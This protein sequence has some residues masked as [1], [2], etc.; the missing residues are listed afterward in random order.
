[1]AGKIYT[2]FFLFFLCFNRFLSA[3]DYYACDC[4]L[5]EIYAPLVS[6]V[7]ECGL[8][9]Q[10]SRQSK[11]ITKLHFGRERA[12]NLDEKIEI[13]EDGYKRTYMRVRTEEGEEGWVNAN[14]VILCGQGRIT[15]CSVQGVS[16]EKEPV[17]NPA[18]FQE[19][20]PVIITASDEDYVLAYGIGKSKS[21]WILKHC[22]L[23]DAEEIRYAMEL[24]DAKQLKEG[25]EK[26]KEI[27]S[28]M[29]EADSNLFMQGVMKQTL[30][31]LPAVVAAPP[32]EERSSATP[33]A[34]KRGG[35]IPAPK[36]T[37]LLETPHTDRMLAAALPKSA[38]KPATITPVSAPNMRVIS[39]VPQQAERAI[40]TPQVSKP[41]PQQNETAANTTP[42]KPQPTL[43]Q[44]NAGFKVAIP[45]ALPAESFS[46]CAQYNR[47]N[48]TLRLYELTGLET[49]E[50]VCYHP[51]LPVGSYAFIQLPDNG[52]QVAVKVIGKAEGEGRI[53][54]TMGTILRLFGYNYPKEVQTSF[55]TQQ[56]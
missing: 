24:H 30:E 40:S 17:K 5:P 45:T 36:K 2:T 46:V 47:Y 25:K 15:T 34:P 23:N 10:P 33:P 49:D 21:G 31:T 19:G 37:V 32:T 52:G 41:Q 8:Y 50:W 22:L 1:M 26:R 43:S 38:P 6:C 44:E 48:E 3:Q 53:S 55:Y 35:T 13:Q 28:L 20:E 16:R 51:S 18:F 9:T 54:M 14:Q 29:Q 39:G 56:H 11:L 27:V 42:T 12:M 7:R 4:L